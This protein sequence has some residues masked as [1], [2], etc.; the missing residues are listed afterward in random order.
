MSYL[1]DIPEYDKSQFLGTSFT[2]TPLSVILEPLEPI[3]PFVILKA[4]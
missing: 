1:K 2:D 3:S 4:A